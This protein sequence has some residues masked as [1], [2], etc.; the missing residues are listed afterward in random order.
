MKLEDLFKTKEPTNYVE[1]ASQGQGSPLQ[2]FLKERTP[3]PVAIAA[4]T[5]RAAAPIEQAQVDQIK[6][7]YSPVMEQPMVQ[8]SFSGYPPEAEQ[9]VEQGPDSQYSAQPRLN[10]MPA[11]ESYVPVS[12]LLDMKK[13]K[14]QAEELSPKTGFGDL[15]A[16]LTPLAVE[17]LMGGKQ[18]RSVSAG[19][20][21]ESVLEDLAQRQKRKQTLED[22]LMELKKVGSAK[23]AG[24]L[25][26][27][28]L[29]DKGTKEKVIGLFDPSGFL[30]DLEGNPLDASRYEVSSGLTQP[31]FRE[32]QQ[33]QTKEQIERTREVGRDL[34]TD[35]TTG[36]LGRWQGGR[37]SP[38]Q[39]SSGSLNPIQKK[40]LDGVVNKFISSDSFKKPLATLQAAS[41][42]EALLRDATSGN[43]V[44]AEVARSEIAKMAEGGGK[45][46]DQ[47][48][49]RV[50]G[51]QSIK[52][53]AR[54]FANLQKTGISLTPKD[55]NDLRQ[56]A[57]T[58]YKVNRLKMMEGVEGQEK[59]FLQK[60]GVAGAV[61]TA[62][63][64]YIPASPQGK[65][66]DMPNV[67][68]SGMVKV[69]SPQ[70]KIGSIP[71]ANLQ[72]ALQNGY[73]RVQ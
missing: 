17:A 45:L 3:K 5:P 39:V 20:A 64:P 72:K 28:S 41:N 13:I 15:L 62:I 31:E 40:D 53:I 49:A 19:I 38:I 65:S 32:R 10:R 1:Q 51:D 11:S 14:T 35:P 4:A 60:G 71:A 6:A 58:L 8:E 25:Q 21:G 69:I 47:D 61:Q 36:L 63:L 54:R 22:K 23:K 24:G 18:A 52:A 12:D 26:M 34:K 30:T 9:P 33:I 7:E 67:Q 70:G 48:V 73:K 29:V 44:S 46:T 57:D 50:G 68:N 43:P 16:S 37:F 59:A 2:Q 27:K 56:L 55:L 66:I 42:V